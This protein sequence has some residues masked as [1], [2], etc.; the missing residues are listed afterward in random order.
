MLA[1][2]IASILPEIT[3]D[4]ALGRRGEK[5]GRSLTLDIQE[6]RSVFAVWCNVSPWQGN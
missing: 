3:L 2:R 4:E 5:R 1:Q 6:I